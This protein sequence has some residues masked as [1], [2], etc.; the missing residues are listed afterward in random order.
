MAEHA[1]ELARTAPAARGHAYAGEVRYRC[2][3]AGSKGAPAGGSVGPEAALALGLA[4][5]A[6]EVLEQLGDL[7]LAPRQVEVAQPN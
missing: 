7:A 2:P 3:A 5:E 6:A 4:A 1:D